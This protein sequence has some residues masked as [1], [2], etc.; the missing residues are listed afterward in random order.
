MGNELKRVL[1]DMG[2]DHAR[3]L[4]RLR[5]WKEAGGNPQ[6]Y[7]EQETIDDFTEREE[8]AVGNLDRAISNLE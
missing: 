6:N 7:P 1:Q 4:Q 2:E 8:K 5:R 3:H